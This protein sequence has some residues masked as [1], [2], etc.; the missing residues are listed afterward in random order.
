MKA[1]NHLSFYSIKITV[2]SPNDHGPYTISQ[3]KVVFLYGGERHLAAVQQM[4]SVVSFGW[5]SWFW[6]S[7]CPFFPCRSFQHTQFLMKRRAGLLCDFVFNPVPDGHLQTLHHKHQLNH[8]YLTQT[9]FK[10]GLN[11]VFTFFSFCCWTTCAFLGA[12]I[13]PETKLTGYW[14][15]V[16]MRDCT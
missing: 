15:Q 4:A 16:R 11:Q 3:C 10:W 8:D 7:G 9:G 1:H 5:T 13:L 6:G 2:T 12:M 14:T